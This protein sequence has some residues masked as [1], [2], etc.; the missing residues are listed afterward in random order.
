MSDDEL[1]VLI[2]KIAKGETSETEKTLAL[3]EL[4]SKIKEF[5]LALKEIL[6]KLEK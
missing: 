3:K 1:K 2:N 6:I 5:N 4:N